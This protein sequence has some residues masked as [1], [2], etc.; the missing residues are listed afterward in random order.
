[1]KPSSKLSVAIE[2]RIE[3]HRSGVGTAV[4]ALAHALS[5]SPIT[6]QRYTF[7]VNADAMSWLEPHVS[8]PCQLVGLERPA[9]SRL[10]RLAKSVGPL[11]A[12]WRK[13]RIR[14]PH[15]PVSDGYVESNN[16]D[17][18][19]FPTQVAYLTKLPSIYQPWDLQHLHFPEYFSKFDYALR[20]TQYRAFCDQAE[21]ICVQTEWTRLDVIEKYGLPPEKVRVIVWGSVF[22]AYQSPS[23]SQQQATASKYRLPSQFFFY[24]AVTWPHK[25]HEVILRALHLLRTV[26]NRT[27]P[28]Y[29]T[30]AATDFR[31]QLD[32][33]ATKLGISE[34]VHY[35]GF[36]SSEELQSISRMATA[37]VFASKF[38][39]FG[40]PVLEAFHAGLPV[41]SSSS[42]VL[43]EVA[44][45]A[46]LF[47]DPTSASELADLMIRVLDEP[48]LRQSMIERGKRVLS[49][50]SIRDTAVQFQRLYETASGKSTRRITDAYACQGDRRSETQ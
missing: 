27:V 18:V 50:F 26:H 30:G 16:F 6:D 19:H 29:F 49:R 21:C 46:A 8:G 11:R 2:C 47:F 43:P 32:E 24:P 37:M 34:N 31:K 44:Q 7:I 36:V 48:D 41:L 9:P 17:L 1:M 23:E 15:V 13:M 42:T 4:L 38:E 22:D 12:A 39:G 35:L 28:V 25:N 33:L 14:Q 10:R 45:D 40:L 20:E 5:E 3:E